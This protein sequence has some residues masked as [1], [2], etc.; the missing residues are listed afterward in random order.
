MAEV[1]KVVCFFCKSRCRWLLHSENGRLVNFE[2]DTSFPL[3]PI[4]GCVR[5]LRGAKEFM[6]H[7][8]RLSFPLKR[9][10]E[11]GE[12]KWQRISWDQALDEVAAR[13]GEIKGKYGAE[14]IAVT[15]GTGRSERF[16]LTRLLTSWE[17]QMWSGPRPFA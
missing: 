16:A 15:T 12:G 17:R 4:K 6:E 8:E 7:P 3:S 14:A 9:A 13:I 2:E 10:G 11:R 5:L 1:R